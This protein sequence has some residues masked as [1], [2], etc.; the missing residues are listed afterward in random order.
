MKTCNQCGETKKLSGFHKDKHNKGGYKFKCKVCYKKVIDEY[1]SKNRESVNRRS[2]AN[3]K[4]SKASRSL[5]LSRFRKD[6]CW[7]CGETFPNCLEAHHVD[8]STKLYNIAYMINNRQAEATILVE[9]NKC[10]CLCNNC[11]RKVHANFIP[12]PSL[13]PLL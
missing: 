9:L 5:V 6:G 4:A 7:V 10:V 2:Q 3:R 1:I 12:C 8:P 11:H 13:R